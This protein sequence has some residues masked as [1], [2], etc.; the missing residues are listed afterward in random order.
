MHPISS[1]PLA[2]SFFAGLAALLA[3][4]IP[5]AGQ[6]IL[7]TAGNYSALAS[8]GITVAGTGFTLTNGN[9]G[10]FPAATSNITGFPPGTVSGTTLLGTSAA[11][12][13]TGGATG[14][15]KSDLQVAATGL[16]AMP[17]S[18]NYSTVDMANLGPLPP[19]VYRWD[20]AARLTGA[21]VLDAQG[22]NNVSGIRRIF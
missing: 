12:V 3:F 7:Q 6:S 2:L 10:I 15:A 11:I 16:A 20:A 21:L 4:A 22:R 13:L 19:G 17:M 5:G 8:Q 14:V 18:A 1:R 9:V